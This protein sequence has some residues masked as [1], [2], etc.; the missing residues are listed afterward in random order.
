[1]KNIKSVLTAATM[2][3]LAVPALAAEEKAPKGKAEP[4]VLVSRLE[5]GMDVILAERHASPIC[6]VQVWVR[7]GSMTEENLLGA[8]VSH[9]VEHMLFKGTARRKTHEMDREVRAA[10]GSLNA[11]TSTSRTVYHMT[12]PSSGFDVALDCLSDAVMNSTFPPGECKREREVIIKEIRRGEDSPGRVFY[13]YASRLLYRRHPRRHPVI[14]Y[15]PLFKKLDRDDLVGYYRQHYVPNN[16]V[17]VAAGDFD[18]ARTLE[19]VKR[20]F[21]DFARARYIAPRVPSEPLQVA[22]RSLTVRDAHFSEAQ[23]MVAWP[24]VSFADD[25]MYPLDLAA[26][27]LG[28]GRTSRLHRRLVEKEKLAFSVSAGSYT[29]ESRGFFEIRARCEEKNV[30]RVLEIIDEEIAG[31]KRGGILPREISRIL[32]RNRARAVF[33]RESVDGLASELAGNFLLTGNVNYGRIY[34]RRLARVTGK[35]ASSALSRYLIP[36]RRSLLIVLPGQEPDKPAGEEKEPAPAVPGRIPADGR[37]VVSSQLPGGAR[38]L[39]CE[40][41]EDPVVALQAVFLG[42]AR[43]EPADKVGLSS[44][45][46]AMLKRGTRRRS[47]DELA[48]TVAATG[49]SLSSWGGR[50]IFG[51]SGKFLREDLELGL[52]LTAEVLAEPTFPEDELAKLRQRRLA[53]IRRREKSLAALNGMLRNRLVY[54]PHPY[55]RRTTS[56]STRGISRADLSG[57]HK[58]FCRPDNMVLC[59][60][61]DVTPRRARALVLKHFAGFLKKPEQPLTAPDVPGIPALKGAVRKEEERALFRQAV[62]SLCFRG[63]NVADEDLYPLTVMEYV[64]GG[65]GGRLFS[66]LRDRQSLA[67]SVGC[68]LDNSLDGGAIVF[69]IATKPSEVD[70]AIK[71]FWKE[72]DRLRDEPVGK[73]ELRRA[74]NNIIGRQVRRRQSIGRVAQ[75]LAWK[76]LYGLKAEDYFSQHL[77]YRKVS[78]EDVL[79]VARKY[80]DKRNYVIAITRP[81]HGD[82]KKE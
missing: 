10:G 11:Y 71:A 33:R 72:I 48:E 74:V 46:A 65:M 47:A 29:P 12:L 25:D 43:F 15:L 34:R 5:N 19:K 64:L 59:V 53:G 14:G 66:E 44:M 20:A 6:T 18:A 63:V 79:R 7:C 45:M 52:Q 82:S 69:Y 60:A 58:Q 56:E 31:L 42:G 17:F 8:G 38:L 26:D 62:V 24:T 54:A 76:Q 68:Y 81:P 28:R 2:L 61:G 16:M 32:A 1:V 50:N 22:P 77:K 78:R 57:F 30:P 70:K 9:Y 37:K 41:H 21:K 49:G 40:N 27:V 75:E 4:T 55:S 67:Y 39:V 13:R 51:V 23:L 80:L 73:E 36:D 35:Q 3:A